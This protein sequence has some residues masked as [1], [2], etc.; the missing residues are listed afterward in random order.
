M[1]RLNF[2][3][4]E[5]GRSATECDGWRERNWRALNG[6]YWLLYF[7]FINPLRW[8]WWVVIVV[9]VIEWRVDNRTCVKCEKWSV[10]F[11]LKSQSQ[12][13]DS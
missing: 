13:L 12:I 11:G 8:W 3:R 9:D 4:C 1:I 10:K 2:W 5:F 6:C 7:S